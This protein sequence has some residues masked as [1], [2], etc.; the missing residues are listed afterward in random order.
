MSALALLQ[1]DTK[2]TLAQACSQS[3][4]AESAALL[5]AYW[6]IVQQQLGQHKAQYGT[7]LMKKLSIA[8]TADFG[9]GFS[10]TNPTI[11]IILS[12][13][14]D[15]TIKYWVIQESQQLFASKCQRILPTEAELIAEIERE[16]RLIGWLD[17]EPLSAEL[18]D[19]TP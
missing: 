8:L 18:E 19:N 17:N 13:S 12:H 5:E 6:L 16:K 14:Q 10:C 2:T 1:A 11:G 4:S 9:K 15:E 3:R 7:R